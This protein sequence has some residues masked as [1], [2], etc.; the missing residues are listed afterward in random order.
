MSGQ[1]TEEQEQSI[2]QQLSQ[3]FPNVTVLSLREIVA[4][5]SGLLENL[6]LLAREWVWFRPAGL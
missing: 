6:S 3:H 2:Q 1:F 4:K 5:V